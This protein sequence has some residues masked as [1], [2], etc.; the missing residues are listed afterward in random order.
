MSSVEK[1][2][3]HQESRVL[4]KSNQP[5]LA[6][7][8][9]YQLGPSE[10]ERFV[11]S[12]IDA[13]VSECIDQF[14]A[15]RANE[16]SDEAIRA[17]ATELTELVKQR[18]VAGGSMPRHKILVQCTVA[19]DLGQS[20]RVASKCVWDRAVD[21]YSSWVHKTENGIVVSVMV[22]ALYHE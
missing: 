16:T 5:V 18:V 21:N 22:F 4:E 17:T 15:G 13:I 11:P 7:L 3:S 2:I 6:S 14:F 19:R 20:I 10:T 9:T 12:K 1:G 8:P